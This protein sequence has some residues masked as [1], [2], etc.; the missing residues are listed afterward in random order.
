MNLLKYSFFSALL[1]LVS[2]WSCASPSDFSEIPEIEFQGFNKGTLIQG[3]QNQD[4]IILIINF[5]D[6]DGDL[7]RNGTTNIEVK[8]TRFATA[9]PSTFSIPELPEQGSENG[10]SGTM[11]IKIFSTCCFQGTVSCEP[12]PDMPEDELIFSVQ[13]FDNAG[14]ESNVVMTDPIRLLCQ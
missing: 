14:N 13:I 6:G 2:I 7:G 12:F 10:I 11:R 3:S 5:K 4:T 8:D 1:V 9:V